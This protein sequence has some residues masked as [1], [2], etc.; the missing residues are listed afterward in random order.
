[1]VQYGRKPGRLTENNSPASL[2]P[3]AARAGVVSVLSEVARFAIRFGGL[4]LL[5]R[6]LVPGDF[7]LLA[8]TLAIVGFIR[9]L[10]DAGLSTATVQR[11][12]V[13]LQQVSNLFWVNVVLSLGLALANGAV[14][15]L[16][17]WLY[18]DPRVLWVNLA[19]S[20]V[21]LLSGLPIQHRALLQRRMQFGRLSAAQICSIAAGVG[22]ALIAA[23]VFDLGYW[24][25]VIQQ[26]VVALVEM[27]LVIGS[28][29][30]LPSRPRKRVGTRPLLTFGKYLTGATLLTHVRNNSDD[31]LLGVFA[32]DAALGL[33]SVAFRVFRLT[34]E[35]IVGPLNQVALPTL[36]RLQDEPERF[37]AYY[38][39]G[40]EILAAAGMPAV[41]FLSASAPITI[42]LLLGSKWLAATPILWL[43]TP[44]AFL[45]T[46]NLATGWVFVALGQTDRRFRLS[47]VGVAVNL[48]A[49]ACGLRWGALGVAAGLSIGQIV[50]RG[51]ALIYCYRGTFL[52]VRD[53]LV[54]LAHPTFA[55]VGAALLLVLATQMDYLGALPLVAQFGVSLVGYL[56]SYAVLWTILPGGF[57]RLVRSA[58]L[59]HRLLGTSDH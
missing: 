16:L 5:A 56:L 49:I 50:M 42:E 46:V 47:M 34:R 20:G 11:H 44:A 1:M 28:S 40:I 3:Q 37:R 52:R 8:K 26:Y 54:I 7:G 15:P 27:L 23:W 57:Q 6:L 10:R 59:L 45:G 29:R 58:S 33:Y 31:I 22:A 53:L 25:L 35:F 4:A 13:S 19:L 39:Q 18:G 17:V 12:S 30:W 41:A 21:V 36:S 14:S 9:L 43:L 24:S 38:L 55:S 2:A 32:T 48:I 51:P